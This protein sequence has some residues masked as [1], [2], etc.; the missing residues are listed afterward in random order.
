[1]TAAG[2]ASMP[3]SSLLPEWVGIADGSGPLVQGL[4]LD[5]RA[6]RPG[7]L[8]FALP[9]AHC[10]G[11]AHAPSAHA[12]GACAIIYDPAGGGAELAKT[13]LGVPCIAQENLGQQMGYT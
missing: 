6:V 3:L 11:M 7:D 12:A 1:M 4:C 2:E 13:S 8:F 9:G 5:S 10:H